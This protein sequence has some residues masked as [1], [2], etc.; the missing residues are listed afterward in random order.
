MRVRA[1][2]LWFVIPGL[3]LV[4]QRAVSLAALGRAA[5]AATLLDRALPALDALQSATPAL[6][7]RAARTQARA[8][9]LRAELG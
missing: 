5:E 6:A 8:E 3:L 2:L 1:L 9:A 4:V 7:R